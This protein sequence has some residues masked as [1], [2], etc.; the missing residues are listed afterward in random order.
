MPADIIETSSRTAHRWRR[1]FWETAQTGQPGP[2]L[3]FDDAVFGDGDLA[4]I[5]GVEACTALVEELVADPDGHEI[6]SMAQR[7]LDSTFPYKCRCRRHAAMDR[8]YLDFRG[9]NVFRSLYFSDTSVADHMRLLFRRTPDIDLLECR[10]CGDVWLRALDQVEWV[11]HLVLVEPEDV[12][13]IE[14]D[15]VW[16]EALDTYEDVW[17][18][19]FGVIGRN[20]PQLREWQAAHNAPE[21]CA[22]FARRKA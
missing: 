15:G 7:A 6:Q 18:S 8:D 17:V 11:Q 16:P 19:E 2:G 20:A 14:T 13:R 1:L 10:E 9:P 21:A 3:S 4:D 22:R 5:M 12:K